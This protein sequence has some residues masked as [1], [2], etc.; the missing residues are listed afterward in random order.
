MFV[1]PNEAIRGEVGK[2]VSRR[3][4]LAMHATLRQLYAALV[5]AEP[6]PFAGRRRRDEAVH[7]TIELTAMLGVERRTVE[8]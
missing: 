3:R 1:E 5:Q 2:L 8:R 4:F 7:R 6:D